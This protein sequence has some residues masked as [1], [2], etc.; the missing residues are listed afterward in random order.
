MFFASK[1]SNMKKIYTILHRIR[2]TAIIVCLTWMVAL[3]FIQVVLRYFTSA[4]LRPFAW[5]DEVIRLSSIWLAFLAA[6]LGVREGSHLSVEYFIN[7][8]LSP[9][10][11]F[12]IK[13]LALVLALISMTLLV[14]HGVL[15]VISNLENKLQNLPISISWFYAAIPAGCVYIFI[16]YLL[17]FIFGYH[18]FAGKSAEPE[19]GQ[20]AEA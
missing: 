2:V 8:L 11:V 13:K 3:C 14:W 5:G 10:G 15:Q 17:I 7:K 6:S 4:S 12:F 19:A 9:R 18:P 20:E 16:D 1:G